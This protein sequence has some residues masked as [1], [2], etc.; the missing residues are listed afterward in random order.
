VKLTRASRPTIAQIEPVIPLVLGC[1]GLAIWAFGQSPT[2]AALPFLAVVGLGVAGL[3]GWSSPRVQL[4]RAL[5]LTGTALVLSVADPQLVPALLQWYYCVAAVYPLLMSGPA[6]WSLGPVTGACYV[7]QAVAGAA[8]VPLGVAVLRAGVLT[9]LGLATWSAGV[10]YRA[11]AR[12]AEA[13]RSAAE[14]AGARLEH[15]A[16]HDEVTGLPNRILLQ[17]SLTSALERSGPT[18]LLLLDLDRFKEV[19]DTLGHRCGDVLLQHVAERL[20]A[21]PLDVAGASVSRLGGDEFAVLVPGADEAAAR[22]VGG[23]LRHSLEAPFQVEQVLVAIDA[24]IGIALAPEHGASADLLLQHAD[25]AMYAAK[26]KGAGLAVYDAAHEEHSSDNLV[27]L[28]ELRG[29]ISRDEL[30]VEYQP[31]VRCSDGRT[32]GVEALVRWEHATRGRIPPDVFI[33]LAERGGFIRPLTAHVLD[34]ALA[35]CRAWQD[36]GLELGVSV[37]LSVRNLTE[38]DLPQRVWDALDRHGVRPALLELEITESALMSD[39]VPAR[40]RL[41]ALHRLGVRLAVDD[42]GTGMSSLSYLKE[43]PVDV[44]KIDKSFVTAMLAVPTDPLIVRGIIDLATSLGLETVAEGVEDE[45]TLRHLAAVGCTHVQGYVLSRPMPAHEVPRWC[46]TRSAELE[47]KRPAW[48]S[49][50]ATSGP[51]A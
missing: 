45:A 26:T 19:N 48:T 41:L 12:E 32:V 21:V 44:L 11:S 3:A 27:L 25:V 5:L 23:R 42:F 47:V 20:R 22:L 30:L 17:R 2:W 15:A 46:R 7:V 39:L 49:S 18:A 33:P 50:P 40:E 10:A 8:A 16:T 31:K 37:N 36:E 29:S 4:L 6:A 43:L 9:A 34:A 28:A 13:G 35:C 1:H 24:S 51:G 14:R 38:E